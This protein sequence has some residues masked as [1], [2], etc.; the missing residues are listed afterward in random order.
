MIVCVVA[1]V[2]VVIIV[3]F[4]IYRKWAKLNVEHGNSKL[5]FEAHNPKEDKGIKTRSGKRGGIFRNWSIG[6]ASYQVQSLSTAVDYP[7]NN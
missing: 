1:I 6:S 3:G 2:A 4:W 5:N 7:E